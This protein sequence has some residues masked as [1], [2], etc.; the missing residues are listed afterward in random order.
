MRGA[1]GADRGAG[2]GARN[3]CGAGR[4]GAR[5]CRICWCICGVNSWVDG[6]GMLMPLDGAKPP[7]P[8]LVVGAARGSRVWVTCSRPGARNTPEGGP[9]RVGPTS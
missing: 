4:E 2:E 7:V 9:S 3:C 1:E 8:P 6:G 5:N